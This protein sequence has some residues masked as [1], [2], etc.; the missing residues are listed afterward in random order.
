M[1]RRAAARESHRFLDRLISRTVGIS[2]AIAFT[3]LTALWAEVYGVR[4]F[5]AI[6]SLVASPSV[7]SSALGPRVMGALMDAGVSVETICG[8]FALYGIAATALQML[9]L[10][11][12]RVRPPTRTPPRKRAPGRSPLR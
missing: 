1:F 3:A 10:R 2:S 9:G 5:G 7:P 12:L 8:I 4:H 6:R 11:G